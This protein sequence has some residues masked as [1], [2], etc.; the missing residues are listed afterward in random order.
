MR[1]LFE[2]TDKERY[3]TEHDKKAPELKAINCI[4]LR[5]I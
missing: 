1:R 4:F 2:Q 3:F 5:L